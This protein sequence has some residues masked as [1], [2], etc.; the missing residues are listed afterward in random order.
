MEF[1]KGLA[2]PFVCPRSG[3]TFL[4]QDQVVPYC[5]ALLE[6]FRCGPGRRG[7]AG[8]QQHH[9]TRVRPAGSCRSWSPAAAPPSHTMAANLHACV[10]LPTRLRLSHLPILAWCLHG[11]I[12]Y[13]YSC[14]DACMTQSAAHTTAPPCAGTMAR[15]TTGRR[16]A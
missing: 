6:V 12:G 14:P 9:N 3:D 15:G 8:V 2:P 7:I 16:L 5:I 1:A 4:T 13:P 11:A 10:P